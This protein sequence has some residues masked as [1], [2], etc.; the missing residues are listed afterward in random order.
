MRIAT[1]EDLSEYKRES[2]RNSVRLFRDACLL[3]EN[4]RY[5]T[6]YSVS[7]L[8]YEELGKT[9]AIDRA[10]DLMCLNPE[11]REQIYKDYIEGKFLYDHRYKQSRA[12]ADTVL[13]FEK[14]VSAKS[15]F[16]QNGGYEV[17]KHKGFYVELVDGKLETPSRINREKAFDLLKYVLNAIEKSGDIGF[18]GCDCISTAQ[19]ETQ[20]KELLQQ[21]KKAFLDC[22]MA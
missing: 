13:F 14:E 17:E 16:I 2:F 5:P 18:N 21:A 4:N 6:A 9:H 20:A 8:S 1:E 15:H 19:S 12:N 3:Y 10:C 22:N 7:V 11:S